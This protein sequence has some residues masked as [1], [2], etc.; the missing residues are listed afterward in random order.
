L[1]KEENLLFCESD[2]WEKNAAFGELSAQKQAALLAF[3]E[4][5]YEGELGELTSAAV[6][7]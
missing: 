6:I 5:G 4:I 3:G 2:K 7:G 1:V